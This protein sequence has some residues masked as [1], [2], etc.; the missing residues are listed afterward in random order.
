MSINV[1]ID[2]PYILGYKVS[3]PEGDES[4][5][6]FQLNY[7]ASQKDKLHRVL[8]YDTLWNL[9]FDYYGNSKWWW[10]IAD[11]NKLES[12]FDLVTNSNL[13]I[14]DLDQVKAFAL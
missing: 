2:N 5:E 11:V 6:R 10:V 1:R 7:V 9:A 8:S 14:P 13:I 12:A 3:Y 4:L